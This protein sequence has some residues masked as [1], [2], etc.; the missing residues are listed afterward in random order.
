MNGKQPEM[1]CHVD[2]LKASHVNA[3]VQVNFAKC[4][5]KKYGDPNVNHSG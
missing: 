5:D 4:L 3:K 1:S 2:N